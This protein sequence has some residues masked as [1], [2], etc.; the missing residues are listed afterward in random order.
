LSFPQKRESSLLKNFWTPAF[1]GVTPFVEFCNW[2]LKI[3]FVILQSQQR[4]SQG[5]YL[6][7]SESLKSETAGCRGERIVGNV[8]AVA[9]VIASLPYSRNC[10]RIIPGC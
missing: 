7:D 2:L 5:F 8:D 10:D 4:K 9:A 3:N 1:A 6:S